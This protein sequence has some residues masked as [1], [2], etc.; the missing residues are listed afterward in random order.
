MCY[1][2]QM[3]RAMLLERFKFM[4]ESERR[5]MTTATFMTAPDREPMSRLEPAGEAMRKAA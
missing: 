1:P 4:L 5:V 2:H 3:V